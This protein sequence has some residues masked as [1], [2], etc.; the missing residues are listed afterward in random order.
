MQSRI[1]RVQK[2]LSIEKLSEKIY[3][4]GLSVEVKTEKVGQL[5]HLLVEKYYMRNSNV[6]CC[7]ISIYSHS[8]IDHDV[9]V[10]S[11]G[12]SQGSLIKISWGA[13]EEFI[14]DV[15]RAIEAL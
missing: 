3:E 8:A 9:I 15:C 14:D 13:D 4:I 10:M 12:S 2:S 1:M 7:S 6:A 5:T 11:G